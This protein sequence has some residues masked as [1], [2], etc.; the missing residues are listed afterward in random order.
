METTMDQRW[1]FRVLR[2][3]QK[4]G[5]GERMPTHPHGGYWS[6]DETLNP[7]AL[8][9]RPPVIR[10]ITGRID[11]GTVRLYI[12]P[13]HP[14]F[15]I[16]TFAEYTTDVKCLSPFVAIESAERYINDGWGPGINSAPP[17]F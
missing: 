12:R 11:T 10:R 6:Y 17:P 14:W 4:K 16:D 13:E 5:Y 3:L 1:V 9:I 2:Y 8:V 7:P 15:L